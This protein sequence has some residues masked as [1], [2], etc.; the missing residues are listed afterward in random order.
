MAVT[1]R[2]VALQCMIAG[3][4]QGAWSDGYLRNAIR[5][6]KLSARDAALCTRIT[7]GILQNRMLLDWHI[8]RL[9]TVPE[10][11][12]EPAV[13]NCLRM[14]I[15]QLGFLDRIP[16]HA[17]VNEAVS[18]T[19][20]YARNPRASGL[21]NAVLRAF[22]RE[23]ESG[24]PQPEEISVRYSH[25]QWLVEE[26]SGCLPKDEVESLLKADNSLAPTQAQVNLLKTT[27]T[28]LKKEISEAGV[29]AVEHAWLPNC[30]ELEDTGDLTELPAFREGCFYVQDVAARVSIMAAD[31]QPGD[32]VLDACAAPGGK[33]FA[34][35]IAMADQGEIISC[36][37]HPHKM[38]LIMQG[39]DR[40]GLDCITPEVMDAKVFRPEWEGSF[41]LVIA[42]VPCSGLGVIRK[43]PDIRYKDPAPLEGLSKIQL[44]ILSNVAR[45]VRPGGTLLYSTCTL[46]WRE[47][48]GV[49]QQFLEKGKSFSLS[50]FQLPDPIGRVEDGMLTL[51]P[52]HHGTDGFFIAKLI[53]A[54]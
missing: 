19:K 12:L 37:I 18:L 34:A 17:A 21:V 33:S 52:H 42:D 14:G 50:P 11:D 23:R 26:F 30:V 41:D 5:K 25:P 49:V 39:R 6:A 3:E 48:Q 13:K 16:P 8:A 31:P 20:R 9:S 36:D 53:R 54:C 44:D 4:K 43:K 22:D 47:N 35:A 15:Y 29:S 10:G 46:L 38:K 1:A 32:R 40:L 51:W 7:Y 28:S 24:L 2:E 45:Y 27:I